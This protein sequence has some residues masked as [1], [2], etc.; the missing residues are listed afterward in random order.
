VIVV[1]M[2]GDFTTWKTRDPGGQWGRRSIRQEGR[3]RH[4][5]LQRKGVCRLRHLGPASEQPYFLC[6]QPS[7]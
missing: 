4:G 5:P 1:D 2:Q 6:Q 7:R 3:G